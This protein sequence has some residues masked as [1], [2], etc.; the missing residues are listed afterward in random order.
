M[1]TY[2]NFIILCCLFVF[3]S[4]CGTYEGLPLVSSQTNGGTTIDNPDYAIALVDHL[5]QVP[6]I[7]VYGNGRNASVR[8]RGSASFVSDTEPLFVVNGQPLSG[9][10]QAAAASLPVNEIRQI[11]VLKNPSDLGVYGVRGSNGVVE[12]TLR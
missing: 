5:R 9:G 7:T 10:L 3:L 11:R 8:I 12:I 1:K 6:G 4:S 2:F